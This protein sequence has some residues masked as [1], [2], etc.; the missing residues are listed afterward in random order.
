MLSVLIGIKTSISLVI[1]QKQV[2]LFF[3]SDF[4]L[5]SFESS[6]NTLSNH[7][8]CVYFQKAKPCRLTSAIIN[9]V[10]GGRIGLVYEMR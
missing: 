10:E 6:V 9:V 4:C 1:L 3:F 8:I 5:I 2:L 7:R